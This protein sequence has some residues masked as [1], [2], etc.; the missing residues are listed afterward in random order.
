M[1]GHVR[2]RGDA[3]ELRAFV[4]RDP[5]TQ[6]KKYLTRTFRGGK[7]GANEALAK[8]VTE[9]GGGGHSAQDATVADLIRQWFEMAKPDLSPTTVRG[10]ARNI[11]TFI[12]PALG[13][14]PLARLKTSQLD[15]YYAKLRDQGGKGGTPLAPASVRQVHAIL[16]RALTQGVRWGWI[17]SNPAAFA[18]PPKVRRQQLQ[19]PE[20]NDV[21]KLIETAESR[22]LDMGCFL[23]LA[24]TTGARR[25]ELCGLRWNDIDFKTQSL[26]ISRSVVEGEHG[27]IIEKDTKTHSSRQIALDSVS[28]K[29]LVARRARATEVGLNVGISL[30]KNAF[31]F[32]N[33]AD[34]LRPW[35]PSAVSKEFNQI[36]QLAGLDSFRLHDLRHFAAT[37]LLAAGISVRTVSGRLG[38]SNAATTLGVYAHFVEASDR[39]AAEKLG[40][41]LSR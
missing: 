33:A 10:Y 1:Q 38:H 20:P 32:S 7:R 4:G 6:R 2:Q 12:L 15:Q 21:I 26:T 3:W 5:V 39:D 18:S 31:V 40:A 25:G 27:A 28:F 34:S 17:T 35:E 19:L 16:R 37:R 11:E 30:A 29:T 22:D 9:V 41:I 36:R 23:R 24:V 14:I 13:P 8:F